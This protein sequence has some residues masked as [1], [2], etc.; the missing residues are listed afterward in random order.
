MERISA[1]SRNEEKSLQKRRSP[2]ATARWMNASVIDECA[3]CKRWPRSVRPGTGREQRQKHRR[4]VQTAADPC[5]HAASQAESDKAAQGAPSIEN[6]N[7]RAVSTAE[8]A[9]SPLDRELKHESSRRTPPAQECLAA[10]CACSRATGGH[11]GCAGQHV[12]GPKAHRSRRQALCIAARCAGAP[13]RRG[14]RNAR[15]NPHGHVSRWSDGFGAW[16]WLARSQNAG[17]GRG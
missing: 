11:A 6:G 7:V 4:G 10:M 9:F 14:G 5:A 17:A 8:T 13:R 1:E 3:C 12:N 16:Q 15:R 2:K